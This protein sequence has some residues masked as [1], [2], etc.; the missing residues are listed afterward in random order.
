MDEEMS[1]KDFLKEV[2]TYYDSQR[3]RDW[4]GYLNEGTFW[5]SVPNN[6]DYMKKIVSLPGFVSSQRRSRPERFFIKF[7]RGAGTITFE[8]KL[9]E[10][11][12]RFWKD[13]F[14]EIKKTIDP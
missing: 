6:D 5:F 9:P 14:F 10:D 8:A 3:A 1:N 12:Q 4:I 13:W 2:L 11:Q 7:K